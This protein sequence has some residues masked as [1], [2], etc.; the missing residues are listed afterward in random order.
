MRLWIILILVWGWSGPLFAGTQTVRTLTDPVGRTLKV[1]ADPRR[2]VALAP[3]VTEIVFALQQQHRLVGVTRFSDYPAEARD[4]PKV[5]SYIYLDVERI[6]ALKPDLCI[7][8][9]DGNP[10]SVVQQ[11]FHLIFQLFVLHFCSWERT[12]TLLPATLFLTP[13]QVLL[14]QQ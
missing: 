5:G 2:V 1:A 11:L 13:G 6:A 3:S 7:G 4:L 9:K 10:I 8:I 14:F 12:W